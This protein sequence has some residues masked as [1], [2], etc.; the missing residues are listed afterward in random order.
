MEITPFVMGVFLLGIA[1]GF[2]LGQ[3]KILLI[4]QHT[5]DLIEA[6]KKAKPKKKTKKKS[7]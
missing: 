7:K 3:L 6:K 4:K 2:I 1:I 5:L